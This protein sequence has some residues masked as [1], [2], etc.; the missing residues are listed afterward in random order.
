MS[1]RSF[2]NLLFATTH[3]FN[4][5]FIK[6]KK[7]EN[8]NPSID[9]IYIREKNKRRR[10][11]KGFLRGLPRIEERLALCRDMSEGKK[12]ERHLTQL[13]VVQ[14]GTCAFIRHGIDTMRVCVCVCVRGKNEI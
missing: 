9:R 8:E 7:K 14:K 3:K 2:A 6:K 1:S 4:L 10:G 12:R 13:H 5:L 11:K